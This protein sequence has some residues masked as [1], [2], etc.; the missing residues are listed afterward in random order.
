MAVTEQHCKEGN[1][2]AAI[3]PKK[4]LRGKVAILTPSEINR[5]LS[6]AN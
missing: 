6:V 4:I 2:V 5:L 3:K 1:P